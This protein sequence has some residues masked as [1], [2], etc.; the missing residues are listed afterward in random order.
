[1][2]PVRSISVVALLAAV[3]VVVPACSGR[4]DPVAA[5]T[6]ATTAPPETP[7]TTEVPLTAGK[8]QSFY[9]P[10]VGDCFDKRK[11]DPKK[12]DEIVL[13]LDCKLP[14]SYEVFGVVD[15]PGKDFPGD[16]ALKDLGK[17]GCPKQFKAYV[18]T[19]YET[20]IYEMGYYTP[21]GT[22]WGEGIRHTV[23][24]YL[25]DGGKGAATDPGSIKL[26]GSVKASAK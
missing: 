5:T 20:S 26:E 21:T 24:C 13:A 2:G 16:P 17:E 6:T 19:P 7:T 1:M 23:G 8:Q 12:T 18:G 10:A 4:G 15:V 9:A 14:H 25:F 11:L 22:T 3:A